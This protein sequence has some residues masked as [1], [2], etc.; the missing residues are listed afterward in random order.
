VTIYRT[1]KDKGQDWEYA[2]IDGKKKK[3]DL[4]VGFGK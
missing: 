4:A 2:A 1:K 3:Y